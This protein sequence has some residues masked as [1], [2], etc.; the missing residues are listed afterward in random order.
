MSYHLSSRDHE[1]TLADAIAALPTAGLPPR[2]QQEIASALR[3][4]CRALDRTPDRIPAE[5]RHLSARLKEISPHAIGISRRRL[6]NIRSLTRTGLALVLP[7]SPGRHT[8]K[9]SPS[10]GP[11]S[12][13]LQSRWV[14]TT[15]SRFMRFC[16]AAGIEPSAVSELTF[17]EFRAHFDRTLLSNPAMVFS[18]M[19]RAWRSARCAVSDWPR[20]EFTAPTAGNPGR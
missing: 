15:L 13:Q 19:V 6:N 18:E 20:V 5:P 11:L 12:R 7:M 9:L 16:S 14:R 3:C 17:A 8:N 2:R 4:I 10:W 1:I